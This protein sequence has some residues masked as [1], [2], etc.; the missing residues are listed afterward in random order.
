MKVGRGKGVVGV[1]VGCELDHGWVKYGVCGVY[2]D[3]V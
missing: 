2:G 3:C 1:R